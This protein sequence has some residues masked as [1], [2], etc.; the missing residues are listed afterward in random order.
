MPLTK[1]IRYSA[2]ALVAVLAFAIAAVSMVTWRENKAIP[3]APVA[4]IGGPFTLVNSSGE[5]I[6]EKNFLGK[7]SLIFFGFTYCPEVCPT[8]LSEMQGWIEELGS[9]ADKLNYAFVSVDP[10]RDTPD[11]IGDYVSSFD[12]RIMP[13]TGSV[14]Q[15]NSVIKTYRV[16]ARKVPLED[17]DYTMDHT[18]G[19]YMM[20]P[21]NQ[22]IG[23]IS[24]G[25]DHE[26]AMKK[27]RDLLSSS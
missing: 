14:E 17:G 23:T 13:L 21:Q 5:T 8:S 15:V 7:P 3:L 9:D 26:N 16:Y 2:W 19:V 6:T 24:Y 12:E 20:N 25:E 1:I 27:I 4:T 11:V 18:A 22:F 10:E